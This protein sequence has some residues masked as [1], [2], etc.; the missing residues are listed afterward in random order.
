[1]KRLEQ[2]DLRPWVTEGQYRL[3]APY[4]YE[5]HG[6]DGILRAITIPTGF[7]CD[8]ASV[9]RWLW[10][11]TGITPSGL[12]E[13]AALLHD[14][15]YRNK[16][17]LP[18]YSYGMLKDGVWVDLYGAK[19]GRIDGDKLFARVMREAGVSKSK[20]RAAYLGVRAGG[21]ASW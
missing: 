9:P 19:W 8:L 5:W 7:L 11:I 1:M 17:K 14:F 16:G 3:Y 21:W 6:E 13:A 12:I 15:I 10:T 20:R 2:P 18:R 4:T